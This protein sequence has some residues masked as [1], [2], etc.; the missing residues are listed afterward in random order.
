MWLEKLYKY[1]RATKAKVHAYG[2]HQNHP[3]GYAVTHELIETYRRIRDNL[4]VYLSFAVDY[5]KFW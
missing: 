1:S 5:W 2:Y 3:V 4:L